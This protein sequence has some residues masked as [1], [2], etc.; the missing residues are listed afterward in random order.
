MMASNN[1]IAIQVASPGGAAPL[2][3]ITVTISQANDGHDGD[4]GLI[5]LGDLSFSL[6]PVGGG[7]GPAIA[8]SE[9]SDGVFKF[10]IPAGLAVETY[11]LE[12]T[13]DNEYFTAPKLEDVLVVY[14]PSLGFTTGGGWFYWPGT[15]EK[16]N[17]GLP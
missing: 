7:S 8:G 15:G 2:F 3:S 13:L 14:D 12:V 5:D 17:F 9:V 10:D 16:T 1:P 11:S 6:K 4:L